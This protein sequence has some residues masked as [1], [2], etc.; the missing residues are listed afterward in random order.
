MIGAA[1][2]PLTSVAQVENSVKRYADPR[3]RS[4]GAAGQWSFPIFPHL[5]VGPCQVIVP[6]SFYFQGRVL[7]CFGSSLSTPEITS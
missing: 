1:A 2:T 6:Y 7:S 4:Q 3:A 5:R